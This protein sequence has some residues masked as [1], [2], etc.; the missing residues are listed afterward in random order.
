[1]AIKTLV[2]LGTNILLYGLIQGLNNALTPLGLSI[3]LGGL[4]IVAPALILS[5]LSALSIILLSACIMDAP[6]NI[7]FGSSA[8]LFTLGFYLTVV[9]ERR[10]H[11]S[12][13]TLTT[14]IAFVLNLG[15]FFCISFIAPEMSFNNPR[16]LQSLVVNL[17]LSQALTIII[18]PWLLNL[19]QLLLRWVNTPT[20]VRP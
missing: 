16:Q 19:Q 11:Y 15:L 5:P 9:I 10:A 6:L 4:F 18:A 14:G 13:S 7:P 3:Y 20:K 8:L 12:L 2:L 1:M 17:A